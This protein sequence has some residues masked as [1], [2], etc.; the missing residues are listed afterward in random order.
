MC[1]CWC[2]LEEL[3]VDDGN[4]VGVGGEEKYEVLS[5]IFN[6]ERINWGGF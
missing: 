2:G 1:M 3:N 6:D 4:G 5:D